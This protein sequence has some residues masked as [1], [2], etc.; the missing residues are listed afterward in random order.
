MI[1]SGCPISFAS[2]FNGEAD[3]A[4]IEDLVAVRKRR[5]E[6]ATEKLASAQT[7]VVAA[8][9]AYERAIAARTDWIANG[10]D[11]QLMML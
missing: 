2:L 1:G 11:A 6:R 8:Q 4:K 9:D 3:L 10:P 5:L 7:E